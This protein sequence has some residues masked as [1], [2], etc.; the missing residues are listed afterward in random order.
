MKRNT[1]GLIPGGPGGRHGVRSD[2]SVCGESF[3]GVRP[4]DDHHRENGSRADVT[5]SASAGADATDHRCL[6]VAE[7]RAVGFTKCGFGRWMSPLAEGK[8]A[9]ATRAETGAAGPRTV[10]V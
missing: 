9:C 8:A 10:S 2:C 3:C 5:H 6:T 7:M 4:F 1:R